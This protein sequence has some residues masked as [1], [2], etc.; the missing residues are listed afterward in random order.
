MS[1]PCTQPFAHVDTTYFWMCVSYVSTLGEDSWKLTPVFLQTLC[2]CTISLCNFALYSFSVINLS[3]EYNCFLSLM[4]H[5][6]ESPNPGI[7]LDTP[8]TGANLHSHL[9]RGASTSKHLHVLHSHIIL[10]FT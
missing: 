9:Q 3:H 5:S 2:P 6:R 10:F 7:I 4:A 1:F 8:N